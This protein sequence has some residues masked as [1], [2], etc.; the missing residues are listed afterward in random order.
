MTNKKHFI[1]YFVLY[2]CF[3]IFKY[4]EKPYKRTRKIK[5]TVLKLY[6]AGKK[7]AD[8]VTQT[9][10]SRSMVYYWFKNGPPKNALAF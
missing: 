2:Y 6:S 1:D 9:G 7:V 3:T 10:V 5:A 8:I 4:K